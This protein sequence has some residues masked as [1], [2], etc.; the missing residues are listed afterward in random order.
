ML[1]SMTSIQPGG[2][3][4]DDNDESIPHDGDEEN[5]SG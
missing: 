3:G 5:K 4:K 2:N 1:L